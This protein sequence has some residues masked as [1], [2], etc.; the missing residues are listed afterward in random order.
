MKVLAMM[1]GSTLSESLSSFSTARHVAYLFVLIRRN[2]LHSFELERAE[3]PVLRQLRRRR[4]DMAF[5]SCVVLQNDSNSVVELER[6][7]R[8]E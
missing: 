4:P 1:L 5:C 6:F 8:I 2:D 3:R 7:H